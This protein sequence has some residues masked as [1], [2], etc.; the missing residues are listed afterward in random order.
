MAL[1][2]INNLWVEVENKPI[3]K[4][5][6]VHIEEKETYMVF[7]RNGSGKSTLLNTIIGI[8][9]YNITDGEILLE[10]YNG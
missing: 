1:L 5:I 4:N 7:G 6:S 8:P 10:E 9:G 3:L 2:E